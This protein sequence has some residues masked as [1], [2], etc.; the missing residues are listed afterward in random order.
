MTTY[1]ANQFA[2]LP[3][4]TSLLDR[5]ING[6]EASVVQVVE[7]VYDYIQKV[8]Q[9]IRRGFPGVRHLECTEADTNEVLMRVLLVRRDG[10]RPFRSRKEFLNA[11]F[12]TARNLLIDRLRWLDRAAAATEEVASSSPEL[13]LDDE[14]ERKEDIELFRVLLQELESDDYTLVSLIYFVGVSQ[15]DAF[16]LMELP[17]ATG[18]YRLNRI[19]AELARAARALGL[20]PS[21]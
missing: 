8:V 17:E 3:E 21:E 15:T 14:A 2:D 11:C 16:R 19:K 10:R 12:M 5:A 6:D 9:S 20:E 7:M 4:V 13:P 18:R 1:S